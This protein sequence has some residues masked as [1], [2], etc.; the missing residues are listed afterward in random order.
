MSRWCSTT[1]ASGGR[2]SPSPPLELPEDVP[3]GPCLR[4]RAGI[5]WVVTDVFTATFDPGMGLGLWQDANTQWSP[6]A[7]ALS[8]R[9]PSHAAPGAAGEEWGI[10]DIPTKKGVRPVTTDIR[11]G[12][13]LHAINGTWTRE[14]LP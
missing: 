10:G 3:T 9:G 7:S 2:R 12:V 11:Q 5:I 6:V 13:F 8:R 4:D 14:D 1:M